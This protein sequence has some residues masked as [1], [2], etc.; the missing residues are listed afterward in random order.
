MGLT[1]AQAMFLRYLQIERGFSQNTVLAY[2]F[3]TAKLIQ[4]FTEKGLSKIDEIDRFHLRDFIEDLERKGLQPS[5]RA[6]IVAS[7]RSFFKY[8]LTTG[9][10]NENSAAL[11]SQPKIP[12]KLPVFLTEADSRVLLRT[13]LRIGQKRVSLRDFCIVSLF[14]NTGM[15][16]SELCSICLGDVNL[17]EKT[18]RITRKGNKQAYVYLDNDTAASLNRWIKLRG[19]FKDAAKSDYLFL[20]KWG[21][22]ISTATVIELV[23]AYSV[24]AGLVRNGRPPT[25]HKLRHSFATRL[26]Q[27]EN[28]RTVQELLGHKSISSTQIY[29]HLSQPQLRD[30]T[31]RNRV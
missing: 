4:F 20:S 16:L 5:S 7:T 24:R 12:T 3:D 18:I 30:A 9:Q 21:R 15:R 2:Q 10:I 1:E 19:S 13:I 29:T 11:L 6:R 26:L 8:L 25:P 14:L 27:S 31:V 17:T 23:K 22:P 28:I